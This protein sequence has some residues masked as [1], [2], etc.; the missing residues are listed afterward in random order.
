MADW[1]RMLFGVVSAV[2]REMGVLSGGGDRRM[3]RWLSNGKDLLYS[4]ISLWSSC[5]NYCWC[6]SIFDTFCWIRINHVIL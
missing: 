5:S 3:Q 2:N 1:I 6:L 4:D